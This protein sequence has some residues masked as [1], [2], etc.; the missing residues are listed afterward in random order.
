MAKA[1]SLEYL[2]SKLEDE[3]KSAKFYVEH[4]RYWRD[5][6]FNA[7]KAQRT[8]VNLHLYKP[9]NESLKRYRELIKRCK[10]NLAVAN[11]DIEFLTK[12][13]EVKHSI[14]E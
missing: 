2:E 4:I 13:I 11:L 10:D 12:A 8:G 7:K 5:E 3:Q 1:H 6:I 14:D 9:V